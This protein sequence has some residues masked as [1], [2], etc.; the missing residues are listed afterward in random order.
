M[1]HSSVSHIL[2]QM[3]VRADIMSSPLWFRNLAGISSAPDDCSSFRDPTA[4]S[5]SSLMM[6][7]LL[8]LVS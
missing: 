1:G 4:V 3:I 2:L 6:G 8:S 7:D 5:T